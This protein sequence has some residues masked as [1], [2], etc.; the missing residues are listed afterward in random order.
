MSS[1]INA[2]I[3]VRVS[4]DKKLR[5]YSLRANFRTTIIERV[6]N[7]D[8]DTILAGGSVKNDGIENVLDGIMGHTIKGGTGKTIYNKLRLQLA[9]KVMGLLEYTVDLSRLKALLT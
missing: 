3:N 5:L 8:I 9:S 6:T 7:T 4:S 1:V 2:I